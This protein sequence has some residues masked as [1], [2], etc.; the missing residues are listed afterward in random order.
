[1]PFQMMSVGGLLKEIGTV[2]RCT[3]GGG[4]INHSRKLLS[5]GIGWEE[6]GGIVGHPGVR[7]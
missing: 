3:L 7:R 1:M 4:G 5:V 2:R 6:C